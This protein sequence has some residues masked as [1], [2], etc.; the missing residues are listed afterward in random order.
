MPTQSPSYG[1]SPKTNSPL[2]QDSTPDFS[3]MNQQP[4][5]KLNLPISTNSRVGRI[6][7]VVAG[8]ILL[9]ILYV[10]LKAVLADPAFNK[11]DY[12]NVVERQQEMIHILT[13]DITSSNAVNLT[14]GEQNFV[15]TASLTLASTQT[16]TLNFMANNGYKINPSSLSNI[17]STSVDSAVQS[18]EATNSLPNE[19]QTI[20]QVQLDNYLT[21][22]KAAYN[23]TRV[24]NGKI[25]L[26]SEYSNGELLI[27]SL[28]SQSS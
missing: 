26:N 2:N 25:L 13:V 16:N 15:E 14:L 4:K 8:F 23:N 19:F 17:Y 12:L 22:L 28:S 3:F 21:D 9:I 27:K 6:V 20:M 7:I 24:T 18:S 1:P 10:I 11:T 5:S